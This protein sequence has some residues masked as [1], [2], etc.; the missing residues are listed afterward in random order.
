M[1]NI[2]ANVVTIGQGV[3][4]KSRIEVVEQWAKF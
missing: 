4:T 1:T 3:G 2:A